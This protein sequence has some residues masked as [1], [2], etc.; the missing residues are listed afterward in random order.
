MHD[1]ALVCGLER[2]AD[3]GRDGQRLVDRK[4]AVAQPIRKRFP[5]DEL[6]HQKP[7]AV[8]LGD[9]VDAGDMRV[10]ERGEGFGFTLESR[11]ALDIAGEFLR[12]GLERH[13]AFQ[14]RVVGAVHAPHPAF[15]DQRLDFV[16]AA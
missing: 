5:F 3:L 16:R 15:A 4:R 7:R 12:Q 13:V 2:F 1:A 10:V 11:Q 6:Q 14:F 9:V 8:G